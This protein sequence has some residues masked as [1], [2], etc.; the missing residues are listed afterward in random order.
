MWHTI[1]NPKS[2]RKVSVNGKIGKRILRK[3]INYI[4]SGLNS[5]LLMLGGTDSMAPYKANDNQEPNILTRQEEYEEDNDVESEWWTDPFKQCEQMSDSNAEDCHSV[6]LPSDNKGG[7]CKW[8]KEKERYSCLPYIDTVLAKQWK[9][10]ITKDKEQG[11]KIE[12]KYKKKK[13]LSVNVDSQITIK[14]VK[15]DKEDIKLRRQKRSKVKKDFPGQEFLGTGFGP[16]K[17]ESYDLEI[18]GY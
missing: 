5:E 11:R 14:Q 9:Y 17:S 7:K 2:G 8:T 13:R 18:I 4:N 3:Y 1:V 6:V 10:K 12:K 16:L 15:E